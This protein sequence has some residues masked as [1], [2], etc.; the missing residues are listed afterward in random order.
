MGQIFTTLDPEAKQISRQYHRQKAILFPP[1][2]LATPSR[3]TDKNI[4][5]P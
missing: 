2:S 5:I 3:K 4:I 1:V